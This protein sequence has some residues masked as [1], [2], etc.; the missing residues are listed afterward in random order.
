L[1]QVQTDSG[2]SNQPKI[3][4][5]ADPNSLKVEGYRHK[6]RYLETEKLSF[7]NVHLPNSREGM[8]LPNYFVRLVMENTSAGPAQFMLDANSIL[9]VDS[10]GNKAGVIAGIHGESLTSVFFNYTGT[11]TLTRSI[12]SSRRPAVSFTMSRDEVGKAGNWEFK[13]DGTGK[14]KLTLFFFLPEGSAAKS[15]ML[16]NMEPF[17]LGVLTQNSSEGT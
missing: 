2:K 12:E 6:A 15:L 7:S 14:C 4:V 16:P 17:D 11:I 10:S 3:F 8:Q 13:F 5:S 9:L 1:E